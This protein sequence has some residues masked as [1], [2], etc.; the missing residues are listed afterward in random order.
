MNTFADGVTSMARN[1]LPGLKAV[2]EGKMTIEWMEQWLNA[3][4]ESDAAFLE[5]SKKLIAERITENDCA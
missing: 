5:E 3:V 1:V 4:I 2:R